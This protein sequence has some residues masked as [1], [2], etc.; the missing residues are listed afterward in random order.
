MNGSGISVGGALRLR[1]AI[2]AEVRREY[3]KELSSAPHVSSRA[4]VQQKIRDE[5]KR[6]IGRMHS[7]YSLY[8]SL[9][10]GSK[11]FH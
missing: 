10:S 11:L 2:E 9:R 4:A 7:P 1:R 3:E 8:N 5:V 6:R